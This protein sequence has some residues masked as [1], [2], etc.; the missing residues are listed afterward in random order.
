MPP[1]DQPTHT[2]GQPETS[3]QQAGQPG[4][5]GQPAGQPGTA[6]QPTAQPAQQPQPP[7]E[8]TVSRP[9]LRW[10]SIS[11]PQQGVPLGEDDYVLESVF[12]PQYNTWEVLVLVQPTGEEDEEDEA[13]E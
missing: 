9:T 7:G 13:E 5:A 12:N 3:G 1:H 11:H 10:V 4:A 2:T 8:M 6:G